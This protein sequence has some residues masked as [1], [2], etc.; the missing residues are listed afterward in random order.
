MS[1]TYQDQKDQRGKP[2]GKP[3][4]IK[5]TVAFPLAAKPP[6]KADVERTETAE[7]VRTAAMAYFGVTDESTATYLTYK[8][9]RVA[10]T[11]TVGDLADDA[12][13][14]KFTLAKELIQG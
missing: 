9:D 5:V 3:T 1:P 13:A 14:V 10:A 11:D 7:S 8:G 4:E 6:Y 2:R 12:R